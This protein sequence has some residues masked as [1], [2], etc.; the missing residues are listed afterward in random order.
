MKHIGKHGRTGKV[1]I[2]ETEIEDGDILKYPEH[3]EPYAIRWSDDEAG[4]VC[5]NSDN[6]MLACV[7]CKMEII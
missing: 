4:F 6:F 3:P 2:N 1:D 7:W 5:E